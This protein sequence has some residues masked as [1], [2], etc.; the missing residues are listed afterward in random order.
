MKAL[1]YFQI[2]L[3]GPLAVETCEVSMASANIGNIRVE[4]DQ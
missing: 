4:V 2:R 3:A 1:A